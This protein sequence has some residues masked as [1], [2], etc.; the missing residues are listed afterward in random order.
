[1]AVGLWLLAC[2]LF[3]WQ[4]LL[5]CGGGCCP[6]ALILWA[7]M[8]SFGCGCCYVAVAL[9]TW[10]LFCGCRCCLELWLLAC[11]CCHV[12][13]VIVVWLLSC[14]CSGGCGCLLW[15]LAEVVVCDGGGA[16]VM[17]GR[18]R[19]VLNLRR[20]T[21]TCDISILAVFSL[22]GGCFIWVVPLLLYVFVCLCSGVVFKQQ[23]NLGWSHTFSWAS[24]NKQLT[25]NSCT[26]FRL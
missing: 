23:H 22:R 17:F 4:W 16:P 18:V 14:G 7:W 8:L 12:N 6:V 19:L 2:G 10:L 3:W 15:L 25:S 24:L 5:S 26:Y 21:W 1:M 20:R 9:I 11:C 13:V